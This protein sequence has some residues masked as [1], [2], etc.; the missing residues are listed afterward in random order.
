ME[1]KIA[2]LM[3]IEAHEGGEKKNAV[4]Q[5]KPQLDEL[6][7]WEIRSSLVGGGQ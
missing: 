6:F 7:H 2:L 1:R 3:A 5:M 4:G